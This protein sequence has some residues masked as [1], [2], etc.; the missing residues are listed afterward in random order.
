MD[1]LEAWRIAN[2]GRTP[3]G[4]Q[5]PGT[6]PN[7]A[8]VATGEIDGFQ[9]AVRSQLGRLDIT[10]S[11][12]PAKEDAGQPPQIENFSSACGVLSDFASKIITKVRIVRIALISNMS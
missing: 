9:V 3:Q 6:T 10:V 1:A 2:D 4:F 8:S 5:N 11:P 7:S 12:P